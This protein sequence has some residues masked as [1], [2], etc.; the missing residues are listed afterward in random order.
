MSI[1]EDFQWIA[2]IQLRFHEAGWRWEETTYDDEH[3][4]EVGI[5]FSPSKNPHAFNIRLA[6]E[7]EHEYGWGRF[8]RLDAWLK[9]ETFLL[10][11][12]GNDIDIRRL[13]DYKEKWNMPMLATS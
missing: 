3:G 5:K 9:A 12:Q 1:S 11:E 8:E 6:E 7:G 13:L 4:K 10:L 2:R